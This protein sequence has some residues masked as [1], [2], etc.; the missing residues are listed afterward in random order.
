MNY[1]IALDIDVAWG[2]MDALGHVNNVVYFRYFENVRVHYFNA[3][4]M[5]LPQPGEAAAG[6][7]LANASCQFRSP[8]V[9]PD[10]VRAEV[11][12]SRIGGSSFTLSYRLTS[13]AQNQIVAE[14]ETVVVYFDYEKGRSVP[15]PEALR[16]AI[17]KLQ[18][19]SPA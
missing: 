4:G 16:Q 19:A 5:E 7:I 14:G 15:L 10:R 9:Y 13:Q 1:P 2:E 18:Q 17:D 11:G 3:I 12:C 6:A 8:V